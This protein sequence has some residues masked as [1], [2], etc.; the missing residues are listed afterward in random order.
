MA[1][2]DLGTLWDAWRTRSDEEALLQLLD[3]VEPELLRAARRYSR[4]ESSAHDL[5]TSGWLGS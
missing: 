4:D 2:T 1:R 5:G 3:A